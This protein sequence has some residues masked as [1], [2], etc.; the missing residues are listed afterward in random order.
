MRVGVGRPLLPAEPEHK[1]SP[2]LAKVINL[3]RVTYVS[4][5]WDEEKLSL[6]FKIKNKVKTLSFANLGKAFG[7]SKYTKRKVIY[8]NIQI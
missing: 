4:Q 7:T 8:N 1:S 5:C 3:W 2:I 6:T